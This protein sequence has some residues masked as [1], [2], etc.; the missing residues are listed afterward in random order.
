MSL[1]IL[2]NGKADD[3]GVNQCFN[4][5][6]A[7]WAG[8]GVWEQYGGGGVSGVS[9]PAGWKGI[10]ERGCILP[11]MGDWRSQFTAPVE[12][13]SPAAWMVHWYARGNNLTCLFA[14][15]WCI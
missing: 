15:E 10:I 7:V 6:S 5:P 9:E 8:L 4:L 12:R 11:S 2:R 3:V 1:L 14:G 13:K